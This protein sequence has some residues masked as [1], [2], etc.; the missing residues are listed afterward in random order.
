MHRHV[1]CQVR[2]VQRDRSQTADC[3]PQT[4]DRRRRSRLL[5]PHCV[6]MLDDVGWDGIMKAGGVFLLNSRTLACHEVGPKKN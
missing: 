3:R 2:D 5:M 6:P 1:E 4:A